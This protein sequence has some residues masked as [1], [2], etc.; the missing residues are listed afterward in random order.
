MSNFEN[1]PYGLSDYFAIQ[2]AH[3]IGDKAIGMR[4]TLR[5]SAT[6]TPPPPPP[7]DKK[8]NTNAAA[9]AAAAAG[10]SA[11]ARSSKEKVNHHSP[12]PAVPGRKPIVSADQRIA[13]QTTEAIRRKPVGPQRPTPVKTS[14]TNRPGSRRG[15]LSS[16]FASAGRR[17]SD[18]FKDKSQIVKMS[19]AERRDY[20][21]SR[22]DQH[23]EKPSSS[24]SDEREGKRRANPY[25][26]PQYQR[27]AIVRKNLANMELASGASGNVDAFEAMRIQ[28]E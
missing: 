12:I 7:K 20:I 25:S 22:K 14:T 6:S 10:R 23:P 26:R 5:P 11:N 24:W 9:A 18:A 2:D 1:N 19:S 15:S 21:G 8:Y 4:D 27:D 16:L 3:Y 13:Q 17:L 28:S